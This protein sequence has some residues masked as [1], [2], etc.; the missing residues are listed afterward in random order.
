MF[1]PNRG[2]Y[3]KKKKTNGK[4]ELFLKCLREIPMKDTLSFQTLVW[5]SENGYCMFSYLSSP[6]Q[7]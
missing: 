1:L 7:S 6:R 4:F 3:Q 2:K 5:P